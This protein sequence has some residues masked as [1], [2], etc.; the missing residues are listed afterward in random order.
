[1]LQ[2]RFFFK[3]VTAW[4][5]RIENGVCLWPYLP[6]CYPG[7][8]SLAEASNWPAAILSVSDLLTCSF[9]LILLLACGLI[10]PVVTQ[11]VGG[12][13]VSNWPTAACFKSLARPPLYV[14]LL[15]FLYDN[16]DPLWHAP[17]ATWP[18]L[19]F[20]PQ[21]YYQQ[22]RL[23]TDV[24]ITYSKKKHCFY[25]DSVSLRQTAQFHVL[26]SDLR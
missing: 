4:Q 19:Q 8:E 5:A 6:W 20:S 1:M 17:F 13:G 7:E 9:R 26:G 18:N 2:C 3:T 12:G 16:T 24:K 11:R 22:T 21:L 23:C 15:Y 10:C 14:S 25:F